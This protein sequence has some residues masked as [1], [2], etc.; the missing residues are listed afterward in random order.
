MQRTADIQIAEDFTFSKFM[1]SDKLLKSLNKMNF[2][3]PSPIQLKVVPLAKCGLDMI[4]QAKSG[5]GKTLA[6]AICLLESYEADL[7]FPQSLVVVPTREIAVQIFNVLNELGSNVKH[8]KAFE[9]IGGTEIADDRKKIQSAKVVVGTPGRILHLI[10]NEI[11]NISNLKTLVLDEADKLLEGGQMGKDVKAILAIMPKKIQILATTATVTKHLE[12][13]MKQV[14][15]NPIGITPKHEIPVLL[16]IKQFVKVL[17]S[18]SDNIRLMNAKIDELHKIFTRITFKQCLL[19]TDS[20]SKTESYGNYLKKRGWK[21]EVINGAQ[22]QS[23]RLHVLD[24]LI[25]FECRILISTD[26]MAR[27]IDIENINLIINL[28]LPFDCFTYLHRI[29]RAGR[30]GTHGIAITFVDG[31]NNLKKFQKMLGDIGGNSLKALKFPDESLNY[32]FWNFKQ[33]DGDVLGTISGVTKDGEAFDDESQIQQNGIDSEEDQTL[34]DNI[35]L[36][37]ITRKLIDGESQKPDTFNLNSILA[38]YE[39]TIKDSAG[40][41]DEGLTATGDTSINLE[42]ENLFLK[43]IGDLHLYEDEEKLKESEESSECQEPIA[44]QEERHVIFKRPAD[45][46]VSTDSSAS[47]DSSCEDDEESV[48]TKQASKKLKEEENCHQF[49]NNYQQF[50]ASNYSQWENIY[51]YQ[52]ANIESYVKSARK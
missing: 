4:I 51:Y 52:L 49:H 9:F 44:T 11:F 7:K 47:D 45:E 29:G 3:K 14:M 25:K 2:I 22:D 13:V 17:P 27:G 35:A 48:P 39:E 41:A 34:L 5:T 37:E 33:A 28:D 16:G 32:D 38:D 19:F 30:F 12:R 24:K 8:F 31:E 15:K 40:G 21:N 46:E 6:F 23:Q 18:E 1:L 20:Q 50:V 26:L 36:L 10:K 43:T 42:D